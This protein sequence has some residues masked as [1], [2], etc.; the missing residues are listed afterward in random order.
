MQMYKSSLILCSVLLAQSSFGQENKISRTDSISEVVIAENRLQIPF[1]ERNKNIE[2][3]TKEEISKLSVKS[4]NEVL[5]Y[6]NGVDVRQRGPFGTQ[7]D[8]SIDGGTFEQALILLNG[9]KISDPQTGHHTMNIPVALDAI[10][11]IEV[12][13]GPMARVYGINALTGAINIV[14]KS[15]TNNS[16]SVHLQS[17]SSFENK[18]EGDGKGK[19]WGGGA[20]VVGQVGNEQ[21]HNLISFSTQKSNGQRY[22]SSTEDIRAYYQGAFE[23]NKSNSLDWSAGYIANEFGANGYYAAPGDK[24]SYELVKTFLAHFSTKHYIGDKFYISPRVSNRY[25]TDDYRYYRND[26]SKARSEHKNNALSFELNS[27]LTTYI[28]DFG[29]G[30]ELRDE[31]IKSTNLGNHDRENFG[32]YLEYRTTLL[33]KITLHLGA[34]SNY[35]SQ[36]GWELFP[37]V[38]VGYQFVPNWKLNVNVG[39]SQRVP[40]FTDLYLKQPANIGNPELRSEYAWQYESSLQGKIGETQ[41]EIRYFYRDIND[42]VDWTKNAGNT[43]DPTEVSKIPYQPSNLGNQ[44]MHGVSVSVSRTYILQQDRTLKYSLGYNNLSP[45]ELTYQTGIISK[46]VL[47]SLKHQ[48]LLRII[49]SAP[50]WEFSTG[51]HWIKRELNDPYFVSDVRLGYKLKQWNVYT[52]I[53][54]IANASYKES[55]AVVMPKRWFTLGLRYAL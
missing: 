41:F 15:F 11:R 40:S 12:L 20:Q 13:R 6:M 22:N 37:G 19:Y 44:K 47:E 45:E 31:D 46:Y 38:D 33:P 18:E 29:L 14:T 9:I 54:N 26:L 50:N 24:E 35:N 17:G 48:A 2:I 4:V 53:T 32:S 3:I 43:T 23:V 39:K 34:Y 21:F 7:A 25:N 1:N 49:Y 27:R 42:F 8:I 16:L 36:Y 52:D 5:A 30:L 51:N 55:G 10:E 28:G